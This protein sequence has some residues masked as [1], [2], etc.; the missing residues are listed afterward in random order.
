MNL[1]TIDKCVSVTSSSTSVAQLRGVT[2]RSLFTGGGDS[3]GGGGDG[4]GGL[5]MFSVSGT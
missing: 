1:H 2:P 3:G 5:G 4:D